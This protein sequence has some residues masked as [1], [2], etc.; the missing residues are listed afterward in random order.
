MME[1]GHGK[2]QA[3]SVACV[4]IP[5]VSLL[6]ERGSGEK[7]DWVG[8]SNRQEV[9]GPRSEGGK[10]ERKTGEVS[11]SQVWKGLGT[12]EKEIPFDFT[13]TENKA[14]KSQLNTM[15]TANSHPQP[16]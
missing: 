12:Q 11:R 9:N 8:W 10:T 13:F 14:T 1:A 16:R 4:P 3:A 5:S 15:C 7:R 2:E 6:D